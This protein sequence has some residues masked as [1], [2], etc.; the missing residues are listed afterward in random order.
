MRAF[1]IKWGTNDISP[2]GPWS[3]PAPW[4]SDVEALGDG[5]NYHSSERVLRDGE[6]VFVYVAKAENGS[7]RAARRAADTFASLEIVPF[8]DLSS[9]I[10]ELAPRGTGPGKSQGPESLS[11]Q[12]EN[13]DL[14]STDSASS[15]S[16]EHESK[17]SA[18]DARIVDPVVAGSIPVTHPETDRSIGRPTR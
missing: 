7:K 2:I 17:A 1:L 5:M 15:D 3:Q 8:P 11:Q 4:P 18:C 9:A 10:P 13:A 16:L 14:D 6:V 12:P